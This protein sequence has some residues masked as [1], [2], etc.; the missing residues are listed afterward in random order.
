LFT[1]HLDAIVGALRTEGY[2]W[3]DNV[4]SPAQVTA[5]R[6]DLLAQRHALTGAAVGRGNGRQFDAGVRSDRT[7]WLDG[8]TPP[9][10]EYLD[11]MEQMRLALNRALILGLFEFEAHYALYEPG[12]HYERHVDA[13]RD[14]APAIGMAVGNRVVSTV[15]YLTDDWREGDG[16]ELQLWDGND[17]DVALLAPLA[18]RAVIFLSEEFPHA[19]LPTRRD[20]LSIAGWFRTGGELPL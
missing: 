9:Q 12:A 10:R 13:F 1:R 15:F 16:G 8:S 17:R 2:W 18:G 7:L 4:L 11:A 3:A 6:K 19:V 14:A 5:L 20:R